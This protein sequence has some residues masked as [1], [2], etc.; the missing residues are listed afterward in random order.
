MKTRENRFSIR[1]LSVGASSIVVATL[2]FMG[3]GSAQAAEK[4]Q[5]VGT[6]DTASAQ[7][8]GDNDTPEAQKG[9]VQSVAQA[10]HDVSQIKNENKNQTSLRNE[11]HQTDASKDHVSSNETHQPSTEE[12]EKSDSNTDNQQTE[13]TSTSQ[14]THSTETPTSKTTTNEV[15]STEHAASLEQDEQ[16]LQSSEPSSKTDDS[17]KKVTPHTE[18]QVNQTSETKQADLNQPHSNTVKS[19]DT[20]VSSNDVHS[21]KSGVTEQ[22]QSTQSTQSKGDNQ[23][24]PSPLK[25]NH[26]SEALKATTPSQQQT[27]TKKEETTTQASQDLNTEKGD[28]ANISI[29]AQTNPFNNDNPSKEDKDAQSGLNTLKNNS[30][31]TTN[32]QSK[33]QAASGTKDQTNKVAKQ[34]QYKNQDPII[35][36]HGFSGFTDDISP[37]V[38]AHYWGGDKLNIRQDLEE[39]GYESYEASI[40]AFG[41]NYDRAVELYYYIKGGTVDYGAAHA[42]KY[43]HERYGKTYEGVYKDWQPGQKVHLVGHSM[44]G[45]TI[46]QLEALLRNGNPEEQEYQRVHGGEISPLYQGQHDNMI[47]SITTLGTPHNGTHAS[48]LLGNEALIRQIVFDAG[49]VLGNK[50]SRVDFGLSQWGLK[51]QPNE[52]YIDYA[53]RVKDSKLWQT[54]DN[55]FYDLTREG[56]TNLNRQTSLN[57]NIVYKTYTGESTHASLFGRQKS[58]LNL[59]FPFT[60]TANV[61]GKVAEKEWRENDG[62]VSVISSQHP[63]NQAFT[64]ATDTNQK[65]I[66]QVTPTKHDWDHIDFVGQDSS[67]TKRTRD[68]LQQFWHSL[69]DDLVQSESLTREV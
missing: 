46:R 21:S 4:Q 54:K 10:K 52:S 7:S 24:A 57:P 22:Q 68:E 66:W 67:D 59:Y 15:T 45:Q 43:G 61:I 25:D 33:S 12:S 50:D 63:F 35:L 42:A 17:T 36:V 40:S 41:S 64:Q 19:K 49:K 44:G 16:S 28:H 30:V 32:T 31:A 37:S 13:V 48:D 11:L 34:A 23:Q 18:S 55:G 20:S 58:D 51:Q 39:N 3:G 9:Q 53:K 1:K 69:A 6:P 38:L 27:I 8:I 5:E 14:Q 2:L 29:D 60:L 47:S 62:L 56:A 26:Q 65:G